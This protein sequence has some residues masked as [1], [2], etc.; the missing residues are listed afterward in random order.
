MEALV[1]PTLFEDGVVEEG[2]I[3]VAV[4][5]AGGRASIGRYARRGRARPD[6]QRA[7]VA[8]FGSKKIAR[9]DV[10]VVFSAACS[11]AGRHIEVFAGHSISSVSPEAV[12]NFPLPASTK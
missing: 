1:S 2:M 11:S 6:R 9:K 12:V 10:P 5:V 3:V 4:V 8:Y 7:A